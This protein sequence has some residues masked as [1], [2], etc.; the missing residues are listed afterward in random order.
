VVGV[1]EV[2]DQL[3]Q[4]LDGVD[5]VVG[6]RADEPHARGGVAGLGDPGVDL[7][8]GQL[9]ALAG[10]GPLGHLDLQL[11]GVH[12]VVARDPEAAR[13]HLLDGAVLRVAVGEELVA[14][15]VL[16]ALAGVG[17][18]PDPVH[19]DGQRLVRLLGD[20][21][22]AHGA[23]LEAADD[24]LDRLHL[25]Q[26]H[27]LG[28]GPQ[29]H[30]AAQ[31]AQVPR[32]VVDQPGVLLEDRVAPGAAGV[33]ELVDGERVEEVELALLPV[34]VLAA[35]AELLV[36]DGPLGRVGAVLAGLHLP[37]D[38]V[39][40]HAADAG[41]GPGEVLV[42]EVLVQAHRLEDLGAVVALDGGDPHLGDH[43]D[44]ALVHRLDVL[45]LGDVGR[46][47]H[48]PQPDLVV[49]GLEGQVGVHGAGAVAHQ[50]REV[51][52]LARLARLQ[53]QPDPG[54]GAL[55]QEVVLH[56]RHRQQGGDGRVLLV[57]AA[58]G[59]DDD[60]VPLG[61]GLGAAV[62]EVLDRLAQAG[63]A[64]AGLEQHGQGDGLEA[65]RAVLA[66]EVADLLQ[67]RVVEDRRGESQLVAALRER[68]EQVALGAGGRLDAHDDLLPDGV[69]R[70]VGHLGEELLEVGVEE[71]RLVGEHRQR[72]VGAHRA[73][74]LGALGGHGVHQDAHVLGG[75]AE[76]LLAAEHGLV[77]GLVDPGRRR[78]V[79]EVDQVLLQPHGVGP[80][81][82]DALLQLVVRDDALLGG[83]HQEHAARLEAALPDH[84]LRRDVEHADLARHHHQVVPGDVVARRPQAVPVQ[85]GAHPRAVGEGD[86]GRAVPGLHQAGVVLVEGLLLRAHR[87][88]PAPGLGDHHH[89]GLRDGAPRQVEQLEHVVEHGRVRPLEVDHGQD[90]PDVVAEQVGPHHRL[91]GVHPVDVAAQGVDLAV[92]RDVA[93]GVGA[94]PGGE[95]VGGEARVHQGDGRLHRRVAELGVEGEE[96]GR[97][98]HPLVDQGAAAEGR[99]V[100]LAALGNG[101]A[102]DGLLHQPA[103]HVELALEGHVVGE[104]LGPGHEELGDDRLARLGGGAERG[105]V[106]G[107]LAPAE[108][109]DALLR[110]HALEHADAGLPAGRVLRQEHH[111]DAVGPG[112]GEPDAGLGRGPLQEGV[113]D[114]GEEAGA[115]AGVLLRARGAA[116]LEVHEHPQGVAHDGVR[117]A[118]LDV[119]DESEPAGVVLVPGVVEALGRGESVRCHDTVFLAAG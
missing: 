28:A 20:R 33:L 112:A 29:V 82:G 34:L 100:E 23:G 68:L 103:H 16:A 94:A 27:G 70:G 36:D 1:L 7:V 109:A 63:A 4:V 107:H 61:D 42:D 83:V 22:V 56:R 13:G 38:D 53:H 43:L 86:G 117:L 77:V 19:G 39:D 54:A 17:L 55:G 12:Q 119:A 80:L 116:M 40:A 113:G 71:L 14:R 111:A 104:R 65:V 118:A 10:L 78:Q 93:V 106:G 88:V 72:R 8:A 15:R 45:L 89:H 52:D 97:V 114:L 3:R 67:L 37:G 49:D 18:A 30:Q 75:V 95:G 24:G 59:E 102:R 73:D 2:V 25:L 98:Q 101:R 66:V 96:L 32:L 69:H 46:P 21:S 5:V 85:R 48:H 9:A 64:V 47:L 81:R 87:L 110:Q 50:Q 31:G 11:L 79:V 41:G 74:G 57:V 6:R 51:V 58:V 99:N 62:A 35:D 44:D 84:P 115:V 90:L 60:V 76:G 26:G 108:E 91:A 92:V 105:V